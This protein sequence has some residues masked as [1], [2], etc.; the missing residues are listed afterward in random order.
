MK[1]QGKIKSLNRY[2]NGTELT[3]SMNNRY[4]PSLLQ[5]GEEVTVSIKDFEADKT[6][7]QNRY[8]WKLISLID[9][10][11]N[12]FR[13]DELSIYKTL[14]EQ[15]RIRTEILTAIPEAETGLK[16]VFRFVEVLE[17]GEQ[18]TYRCY[19]GLS[20]FTKQETKDFI[21]VLIQRC[22]DEGIEYNLE[23]ERLT[24][25]GA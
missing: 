1:L 5:L 6:S 15:A 22:V 14:I 21:E 4:Y 12:G 25:G 3:L 2:Y 17:K 24:E 7:Q 23:M 9:E 18:N 10:K 13:K 19:Y 11:I 8:I 20:H 16:E